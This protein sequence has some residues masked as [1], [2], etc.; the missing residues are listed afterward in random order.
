MDESD[1][2]PIAALNLGF[3]PFRLLEIVFKDF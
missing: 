3:S 1:Y 2:I